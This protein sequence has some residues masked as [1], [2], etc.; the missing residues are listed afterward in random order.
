MVT[1]WVGLGA[2][3]GAGGGTTDVGGTTVAVG[4]CESGGLGVDGPLPGWHSPAGSA[5]WPGL[6]GT[7]GLPE[8]GDVGGTVGGI[9]GGTQLVHG[10]VDRPGGVTGCRGGAD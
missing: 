8:G 3:V 9:D 1:V 2:T 6:G 10:G 5:H 7:Y 4:C